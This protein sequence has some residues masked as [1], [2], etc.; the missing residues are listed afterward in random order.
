M[1][2]PHEGHDGN[3][4]YSLNS[5]FI[6]ILSVPLVIVPERLGS[7]FFVSEYQ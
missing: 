6:V 2:F 7:P 1:D 5:T 4:F 3:Y